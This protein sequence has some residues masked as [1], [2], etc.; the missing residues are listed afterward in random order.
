[1]PIGGTYP[2]D[3]VQAAEFVNGLRPAVAIP[4]HYGTVVGTHDDFDAF[5]AAVDPAI[6]VVKKLER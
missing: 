5:A 2:C 4:T 3:P 6:R 1:M